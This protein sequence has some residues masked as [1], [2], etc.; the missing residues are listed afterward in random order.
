M[1]TSCVS[2]VWPTSRKPSILS[3]RALRKSL[4]L[5]F[6]FV[7]RRL[8][9]AE[10]DDVAEFRFE[11][12][13]VGCAAE[14][15]ARDERRAGSAKRVEYD[16][17]L[18]RGIFQQL[19]DESD[20]LHGGMFLVAPRPRDLQHGGRQ[21]LDGHF[22]AADLKPLLTQAEPVNI[23]RDF[24]ERR[25]QHELGDGRGLPIAVPLVRAGR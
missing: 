7:A 13:E 25:M 4:F 1:T 3:M 16:V 2:S 23:R 24:G 19:V 10:R 12:A 20:R 18:L 15:L 8:L 21:L 6:R 17:A 11:F 14:L 5:P 22:F 9:P